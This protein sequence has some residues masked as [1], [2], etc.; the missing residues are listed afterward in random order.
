M[1]SKQKLALTYLERAPEAAAK[2]LETMPEAAIVDLLKLVSVPVG[3]ATLVQLTSAKGIVCIDQLDHNTAAKLLTQISATHAAT[4]LKGLS[5]TKTK[6]ILHQVPKLKAQAI[7]VLLAYPASV[8]GA[9]ITP[10]ALT[11]RNNITV[12]EAYQQLKSFQGTIQHR[13][14][15]L[16]RRQKL[17]GVIAAT[18]VMGKVDEAK[19]L[20]ELM[21]SKPE[22]LRSRMQLN[23]AQKHPDWSHSIVMPVVN[24]H[25]EFIG[26]LNYGALNQAIEQLKNLPEKMMEAPQLSDSL[27]QLLSDSITGVWQTLRDA[28]DLNSRGGQNDKR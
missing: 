23:Q 22:A 7:Q 1:E 16:D 18:D 9:W 12:A 6:A 26:V 24:R 14:F 27:G 13:L 19:K 4:L 20:S 11:L 10:Q 17:V 2:I 15:I 3:A 21:D 5:Q 8:V 25:D 28:W